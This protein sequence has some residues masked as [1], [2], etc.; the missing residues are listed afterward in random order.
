MMV[1]GI[2]THPPGYSTRLQSNLTKALGLTKREEQIKE[3]GLRAP[4]FFGDEPLG[5]LRVFRYMNDEGTREMLFYELSWV[6]LTPLIVQSRWK[7]WSRR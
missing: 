7:P 4:D 6:D 5:H 2:G 3:L 1:H